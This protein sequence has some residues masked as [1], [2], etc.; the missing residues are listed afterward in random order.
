MRFEHSAE[1]GR[2]S[3]MEKFAAIIL[4]AFVYVEK[5]RVLCEQINSQHSSEA[6]TDQKLVQTNKAT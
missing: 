4:Y 3:G 1:R 6:L 5:A 2:P